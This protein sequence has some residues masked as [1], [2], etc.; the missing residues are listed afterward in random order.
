MNKTELIEEIDQRTDSSKGEAQRHVEGF[1]EVVAEVLRSGEESKSPASGSSTSANRRLGK[2]STPKPK[3]RYTFR[4][5]K[6]LRSARAKRSRRSSRG[7]GYTKRAASS[8][9][10]YGIVTQVIS[11]IVCELHGRTSRMQIG[12]KGHE[13]WK[14]RRRHKLPSARRCPRLGRFHARGS[15][16]TIYLR[17]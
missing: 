2:A 14:S 15:E 6:C 1:E 13:M 3:R 8:S 7:R 16:R 4:P 17:A 5:L 9:G 11:E 10:K 12:F